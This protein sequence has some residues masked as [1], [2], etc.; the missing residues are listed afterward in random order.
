MNKNQLLFLLFSPA[1][2]AAEMAAR[3]AEA[4][5]TFLAELPDRYRYLGDED[6]ND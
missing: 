2:L 3:A 4:A 6:G 5:K 1:I